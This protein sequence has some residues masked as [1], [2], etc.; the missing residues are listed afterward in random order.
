MIVERD[1][2]LNLLRASVVGV[3]GF[4]VPESLDWP[5]LIEE[6]SR[7]NVSVIASD[8]LQKLFDAGVYKVSGDKEEKRAKA[9]WFAKTMKYEQRYAGQLAAAKRMGKWFAD[10]G[11]QTVVLKGFTISECYPV[12]SHR[13]SADL[14]CYLIKDGEHLDTYEVGNQVAEKH[15][16]KVSRDY[17]KN[18]SFNISGLHV[19]NHKF[20]TPFRGNDTLRRLERLLQ[21][22]I[23]KGPLTDFE[24]TGLLM[25][26]VLASALFLTEHAY[27]HFL[28]EG[29]NL[30]HILDWALFHQRHQSDVDWAEFERYVD[31][32]EF[33]RFYKAFSHVGDFVLG[34]REYSLLTVPEQKMIDSVWAGLDLHEDI[35]GFMGKMR[36]AGNTFR[37]GWKYQEFAPISMVKALAIQVKGF[38]FERNP[39][40]Y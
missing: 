22:M 32:F 7:Q 24:D 16:V 38:L 37:A 29:L 19:E 11:I 9:R 23:L 4:S 6:A 36:L 5:L 1:F 39:V 33:R 21:E 31:E 28:H 8:G 13:Y 20:C 25:P 35:R 15:G 14:D 40:L 30:R 2:L 26:P 34:E 3:T 12:P 27:S 18:S 10:E 17:Y